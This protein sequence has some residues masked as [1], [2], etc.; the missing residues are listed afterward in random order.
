[1]R[2]DTTARRGKRLAA[3]VAV[4]TLGVAACGDDDGNDVNDDDVDVELPTDTGIPG[5]GGGGVG[6]SGSTPSGSEPGT[7]IPPGTETGG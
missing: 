3:L 1:M 4:A 5:V 7:N 6:P 2:G